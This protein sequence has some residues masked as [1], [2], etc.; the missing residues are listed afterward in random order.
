M[1]IDCQLHLANVNGRGGIRRDLAVFMDELELDHAVIAN[2]DAASVG[3]HALDRDELDANLAILEAAQADTRLM[4]L[5]WVR[6]GRVDSNLHAFA[7]ALD[8]EPFCGALFAPLANGFAAADSRLEPYLSILARLEKPA[9]FMTGREDDAR[10]Q[11][12]YQLAKRFPRVAVV[13][14]QSRPSAASDSLDVLAHS[15][16]RK[17]ARLYASTAH[18]PI[19]EIAVH[20][21]RFGCEGV[22]FGSDALRRP[23]DNAQAARKVLDALRDKLPAPAFEEIA[24]TSAAR[25]L[26]LAPIVA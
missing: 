9:C 21:S 22:L 10:P 5:Y 17:D 16:S 23:A 14:L 6:P 15:R 2:R 8:T 11:R 19:D 12:V 25:L 1:F 18:L 7:G 13:L 3:D 4:P 20:V 26:G 24:G